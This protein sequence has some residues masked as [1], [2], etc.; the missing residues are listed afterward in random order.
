M[1]QEQFVTL[2]TAKLLKSKGF[3][4]N[5]A[6]Y[7]DGN[8]LWRHYSGEILPKRELFG[9]PTQQMAMKWLREVHNIGVFPATYTITNAEG[10]E[11]YYTYGTAIVN[12]ITHELMLADYLP[13][14]TY[15]EAVEVAL[16]YCLEHFID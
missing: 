6:H 14:D 16:R 1:I 9:A 4:Q 11:A 13:K 7:Y 15:E 8:H 12:L 3:E 10:T 5:V 2:E